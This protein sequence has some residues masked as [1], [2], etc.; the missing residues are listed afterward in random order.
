MNDEIIFEN[1]QKCKFSEKCSQNLCPLDFELHLRVGGE[2]DKCR[3]MREAKK[4][5]VKGR[6]FISGGRVMPKGILIFVP[7]ESIKCLNKISQKQ[8]KIL[9]KKQRIKKEI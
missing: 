2:S 4:K 9:A 7:R 5:K 3:W 8:W 1:I 6:E